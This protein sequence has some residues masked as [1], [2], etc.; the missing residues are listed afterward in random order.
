MKQESETEQA[1]TAGS[2]G[3]FVMGAW[4]GELKCVYIHPGRRFNISRE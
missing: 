3:I 4:F 2:R 1:H